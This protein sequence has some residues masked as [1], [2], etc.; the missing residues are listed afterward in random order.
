MKKIVLNF[1]NTHIYTVNAGEPRFSAFRK[2]ILKMFILDMQLPPNLYKYI[3]I[4]LDA[5]IKVNPYIEAQ[6][7]ARPTLKKFMAAAA[8]EI[9]PDAFRKCNVNINCNEF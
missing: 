7:S 6:N 9:G 5:T 8:G 4:L 1:C 2:I 3:G